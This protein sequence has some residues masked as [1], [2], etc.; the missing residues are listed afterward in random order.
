MLQHISN[1]YDYGMLHYS[2]GQCLTLYMHI[3]SYK[4]FFFFMDAKSIMVKP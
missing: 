1:L 2:P 3:F 4:L